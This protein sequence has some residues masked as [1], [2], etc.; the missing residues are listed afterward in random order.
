MSLQHFW[1]FDC[2]FCVHPSQCV[3]AD[4]TCA[5]FLL[6]HKL[7]S[8]TKR[9]AS[10]S[11]HIHS[12]LWSVVWI[13]SM[14]WPILDCRFWWLTA[15]ASALCVWF[16]CRSQICIWSFIDDYRWSLCAEL[17]PFFSSPPLAFC[18]AHI[19]NS[20]LFYRFTILSSCCRVF[21]IFRLFLIWIVCLFAPLSVW[22]FLFA[23]FSAEFASP[24]PFIRARHSSWRSDYYHWIDWFCRCIRICGFSPF[25]L[26]FRVCLGLEILWTTFLARFLDSD[27]CRW[28]WLPSSV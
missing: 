27:D 22:F 17:F 2:C 14:S 4:S 1:F 20:C 24:W 10:S 21:A 15:E 25:Q 5:A 18:P 7:T 8:L 23:A 11:A 12:P 3:C 19:V 6:V 28:L 13:F 16:S 26:W 9:M